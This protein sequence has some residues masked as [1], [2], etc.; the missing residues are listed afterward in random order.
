MSSIDTQLASLKLYRGSTSPGRGTLVGD[1][2]S[3][4]ALSLSMDID[5]NPYVQASFTIPRPSRDVLTA[6]DPRTYPVVSVHLLRQLNASEDVPQTLADVTLLYGGGTLADVTTMS[7]G[8]TEADASA[9]FPATAVNTE[10]SPPA[11]GPSETGKFWDLYITELAEGYTDDTLTVTLSSGE[12]RLDDHKRVATSASNMASIGNANAIVR[13]IVD[14]VD[15]FLTWAGGTWTI[16]GESALWQP[17]DSLATFIDPI[18][19]AKNLR[20][21]AE[22]AFEYSV[23]SIG[24]HSGFGGTGTFTL[25]HT[26]GLFDAGRELS[27]AGS[28]VG[29]YDAAVV[30]YRWTNSAGT[31]QTAYDVYPVGG[32]NTRTRVVTREAAYPGPGAAQGIVGRST[33]RGYTIAATTIARYDVNPGWTVN[34]TLPDDPAPQNWAVKTVTFGLP[35]GEMTMTLQ[36]IGA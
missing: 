22:S 11:S 6:M 28:G 3:P 17:G 21:Y 35:E 1:L 13:D 15:G 30:I 27:A 5:R 10:W 14:R 9:D 20:I 29:W 4:S 12:F 18:L 36:A 33:Q 26:D 32:A 34:L 31:Q 8:G 23:A 25:H 2:P 24:Q 16:E 7:G 19:E